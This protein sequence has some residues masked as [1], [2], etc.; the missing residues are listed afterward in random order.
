M[1]VAVVSEE[2]PGALGEAADLVVGGPEAL[3]AL[4]EELA[5]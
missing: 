1:R 2:G 5:V 3:V 4:L